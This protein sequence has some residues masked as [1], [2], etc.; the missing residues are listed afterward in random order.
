M[1]PYDTVTTTNGIHITATYPVS[2]YALCYSPQISTAFT[3]YPTTMLGTYYCVMARESQIGPPWDSQFAIGIF[4]V[5][6]G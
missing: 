1:I 5:F 4:E 2:V 6:R 3:V